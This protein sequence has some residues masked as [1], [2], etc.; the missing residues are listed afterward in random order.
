MNRSQC[1]HLWKEAL[2]GLFVGGMVGR[3]QA[4]CLPLELSLE[5]LAQITCGNMSGGLILSSATY[6]LRVLAPCTSFQEEAY[7]TARLGFVG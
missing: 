4:S 1:T 5:S 3:Y 2:L 7:G 6:T